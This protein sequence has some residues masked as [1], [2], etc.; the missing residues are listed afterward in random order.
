MFYCL[1]SYF[2]DDFVLCIRSLYAAMRS[3]SNIV[4]LLGLNKYYGDST[5]ELN[6]KP[7]L[8]YPY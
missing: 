8:Q 1:L 5:A 3:I 6:S 4:L 7:W 2:L